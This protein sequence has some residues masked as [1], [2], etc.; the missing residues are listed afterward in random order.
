MRVTSTLPF[1]GQVVMDVL[2]TI[3][4]IINKVTYHD[5]RTVHNTT[6]YKMIFISRRK[7]TIKNQN[8]L[9]KSF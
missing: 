7:V 9:V 1:Q 2:S 4:H 8:T 5:A 3:Y 6:F